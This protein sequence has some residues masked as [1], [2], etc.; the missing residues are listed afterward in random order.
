[1]PWTRNQVKLLLS[2]VSPLSAE[3][4]D[5]MKAELHSNPK[6]AQDAADFVY[7]IIHGSTGWTSIGVTKNSSGSVVISVS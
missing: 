2:K 6:D 5:K 1:M 3:Q 7:S 4:Q